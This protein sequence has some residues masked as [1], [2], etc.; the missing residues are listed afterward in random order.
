MKIF[1][2]AQLREWDKATIMREGIS[3][4][5]LMERAA[6]QCLRWIEESPLM[7]RPFRIFCGNGNNGGDGLALARML[8]K[9]EQEVIVY[10]LNEGRAGSP[11]FNANKQRLTDLTGVDLRFINSESDL[12]SLNPAD[13][14]IDALYGFGLNRPPDGLSAALIRH[15]NKQNNP[16]IS[17]DLPSGLYVE[18]SSNGNTIIEADHTLSFQVNKL[19]FAMAE[20]SIYIGQIHLLPIGLDD[21]YAGHTD[22]TYQWVDEDIIHKLYKPR[23]N[24]AH[25][26]TYGHALLI[27]GGYGKMGA[28]VLAAKA[29]LHTGVGLLTCHIP[30]SGYNIMQVS[31]PEAMVVTDFNSS[32]VTAIDED[33]SKYKTIGTGPGLGK[34]SETK[35]FLVK[36]LTDFNKPMVIDA[37]ALNMIGDDEDLQRKI[38]KDSILTPHPKEFERLFGKAPDEFARVE[39]AKKKAAE[40]G[41]VIIVKGHHTLVATPDGRAFFNST[42]NAGMAKGGSGDTLTGLLTSL[43]AQGYNPADAAIF[44]VWLHGKAGDVAAKNRS[45]EAM[46]ATDLINSIGDVFLE[47]LLLR[48][49]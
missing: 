31:V 36:L 25:K 46:L 42:G 43:L 19:A 34:A 18:R 9:R 1:S 14:I 24:F 17:I 15:L 7:Y 6:R 12:P 22:T 23:N 38:P 45:M 30:G 39:L 20:N 48:S 11:D 47:L 4:T 16:V 49:R 41:L 13:V 3:S 21:Q 26:G 29:C 10:L 44:G 40:L 2:V 28:A 35:Q 5:D 33:L 8:L 27:A 32:Y 37:D